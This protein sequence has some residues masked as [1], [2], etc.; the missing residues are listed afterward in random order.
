MKKYTTWDIFVP[1]GLLVTGI[2]WLNLALKMGS[3]GIGDSSIWGTGATIPKFMLAIFIVLN[4]WILI[5]ELIKV[6]KTQAED[7]GEKDKGGLRVLLMIVTIF[8]YTLLLPIITYI[9]AT[10]ILL[11]LTMRLFNERRKLLLVCMPVGFTMFLYTVFTYA[12]K[13]SL[14]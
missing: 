10:I 3:S 4:V 12:L 13:I 1:M 5:A 9:P 2:V 7:A 6:G 14:P 11:F 8:A